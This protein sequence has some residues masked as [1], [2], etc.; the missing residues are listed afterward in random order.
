MIIS[1]KYQIRGGLVQTMPQS[2]FGNSRFGRFGRNDIKNRI[3][4]LN[5]MKN[6]FDGLPTQKI[7]VVEKRPEIIIREKKN[8]IPVEEVLNNLEEKDP[9]NSG[10]ILTPNGIVKPKKTERRITRSQTKRKEP[11]PEPEIKSIIKPIAKENKRLYS[12]KMSFG[13]SMNV[14]EEE[15]LKSKYDEIREIFNQKW[16]VTWG[17]NNT[18]VT[19][20]KVTN[21]TVPQVQAPVNVA[22]KK[23]ILP[24]QEPERTL[25]DLIYNK[26]T[27]LGRDKLYNYL[28]TN[29]PLLK[30]ARAQV[31]TYIKAQEIY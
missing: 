10:I 27:I 18:T 14:S 4:L 19:K 3:N 15:I 22:P 24:F 30:A 8:D 20:E 6:R 13:P 21:E 25:Y 5:N 23:R 12:V 1:Q 2:Q 31:A 16:K 7:K 29:Y 9:T 28:K 26:G 11:L 17:D